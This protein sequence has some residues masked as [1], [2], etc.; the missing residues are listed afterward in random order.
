MR[1]EGVGKGLDETRFGN[2]FEAVLEPQ[3]ED[4]QGRLPSFEPEFDAPDES[5][6][7]AAARMNE[8]AVGSV[9]VVDGDRPIGILTE[10]DMVRL[11]ASGPPYGCGHR[12][13]DGGDPDDVAQVR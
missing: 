1:P 11:A 4:V 13:I 6:A 3:P 10:R 7:D 9:V 12:R 5:V 8:R 2:G